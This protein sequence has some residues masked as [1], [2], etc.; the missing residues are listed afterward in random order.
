MDDLAIYAATVPLSAPTSSEQA[1]LWSQSHWPTV[2]KKSN[3]F[4]PHPSIIA[5]AESEMIGDVQRWTGIALRVAARS[6][7]EGF[8]API[9]AVIVDRVAHTAH[10]VAVAGDGRWKDQKKGGV[11]NVMAHAVLR[12]I[13]MVARKIKATQNMHSPWEATVANVEPNI[14]L[15]YPLFAEEQAIFES[16]SVS[17]SGYL[18]HGLE[19]YLTHEPCV[20]CSM[21]LLHS[22]FGRVV[23]GRQMPRTGGLCGEASGLGHGLFWR[24]GLNWNLLAWQLE[25]NDTGL[26]A[27][28]EPL[29]EA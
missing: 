28:L 21:A 27:E 3:P 5:H 12:A 13:G 16:G 29:V 2:Y 23:F 10:A 7:S 8:G 18:C 17:P 9:G 11:G 22:R 1:R 24:K 6:E 4:G 19:I 20:M 25:L 14:Y 26:L 15:D